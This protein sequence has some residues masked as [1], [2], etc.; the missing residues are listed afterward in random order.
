MLLATLLLTLLLL[1]RVTAAGQNVELVK[2]VENQ[3]FYWSPA[4]QWQ[5]A[6]VIPAAVDTLWETDLPHILIERVPDTPGNRKVRD[7]IIHH[8]HQLGGPSYHARWHVAEHTFTA[9]TPFGPKEMTNVIVTW[10][11]QDAPRIVLAA[12]YDSKF[13]PGEHFV[14]ATDSAAPV[15]MLLSLATLLDKMPITADRAVQFIF[16]DGEEAFVEWSAFD[17]M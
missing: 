13:M 10:G 11:P 1:F 3:C 8:F 15:A 5:S 16:F 7:Y 14:G 4:A 12:H 6:L 17:A 9:Q 2:K